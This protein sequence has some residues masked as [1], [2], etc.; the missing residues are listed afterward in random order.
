MK[1]D[2][3]LG[4]KVILKAIENHN[5]DKMFIKWLHDEA[6]YEKSFE[7]YSKAFEP[8]RKSSEKEKDE[9]LKKW[10]GMNGTV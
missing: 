4:I 8:Y 7:E 2:A 1:L 9:I 10:G 5:Q 6:R 3:E